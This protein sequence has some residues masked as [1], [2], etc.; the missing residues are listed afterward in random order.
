M[1]DDFVTAPFWLAIGKI[2]WI[3]VLL[4]GDNA[5]VIALAARNLP[6]DRQRQAVLLG[7]AGAIVLRVLLVFFAVALLTLPYVKLVGAV[8][9]VYI[10]IQLLKGEDNEK[11]IDP[12][13][14]LF[15]AVR[16]ILVADFVMSLDNVLAVA[17]V[18]ETA[19]PSS[20]LLVLVLGL[21]LTIPLIMFGSTLLLKVIER[22]P[23]IV[24]AGAA[25]LG[26][27]AGEM[28]ASDP[29]VE[30]RGIDGE[31]FATGLG[32]ALA[33]VVVVV[34]T[35]LARRGERMPVHR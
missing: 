14:D 31:W 8:L 15:A 4:S 35:V 9:L 18:A 2:V 33:L 10:G 34:G 19:P 1:V 20:R 27:V 22:I 3:D 25:L 30:G 26:F 17:A 21:G 32:V 6:A 16:T 13:R 24:T 5:V 7:S 29:I 11:K 12:A 23:L 28:A